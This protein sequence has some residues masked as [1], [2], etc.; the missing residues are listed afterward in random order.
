LRAVTPYLHPR[1]AARLIDFLQAAFGA[2]EAA[3]HESP[4]GGIVHAKVRVGDSIIEMGEAHDE[5]QPMATAFYL[6]VDDV[7]GLHTRAV[8]AGAISAR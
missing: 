7:D 8:R 4:D 3:R 1:G 2:E 6:Y 5:W